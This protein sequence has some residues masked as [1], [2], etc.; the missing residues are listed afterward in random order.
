MDTNQCQD[1]DKI[2]RY[3]YNHRQG[4]AWYTVYTSLELDQLYAK[5]LY[6]IADADGYV[7]VVHK[8]LKFDIPDPYYVKL[9][10]LGL[11]FFARTNYVKEHN[12]RNSPQFSNIVN[13][14][15]INNLS[16]GIVVTG[17]N[18]NTT[19]LSSVK[20]EKRGIKNPW[21]VTI[22]GGLLLAFILYMIK[23]NFDIDL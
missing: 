15:N 7:K 20:E 16:N 22:V 3:L 14:T 2:M 17:D 21:L 10:D 13:N 23:E 4:V 19:S 8:G 9:T 1:L 18:N 5:S 6:E 11:A 12:I